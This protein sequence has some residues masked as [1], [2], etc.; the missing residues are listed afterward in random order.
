M[1][2]SEQNKLK[3]QTIAEE[4][5]V[6][7]PFLAQLLRKL[8]V[9]HLVSSSKGPGGGFFLN[10]DNLSNTLWDIIVSIDG[11]FKF[12]DC[13]L[14]LVKCNNVNPCPVHHIVSPFK[15][16]LLA[17]FKEKSIVTLVEEMKKDGTIISLK[18]II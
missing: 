4:L 11:E 16:N 8:T 13:F 9:D 5:E 15:E 18:G 14:G 6:P 10:E 17:H 3:A 2:S 12:D 7:Q 1:K